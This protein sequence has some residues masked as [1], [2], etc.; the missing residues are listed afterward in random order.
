MADYPALPLLA[1]Y[2][3][4][5]LGEH[6]RRARTPLQLP[7]PF[8]LAGA[9]FAELSEAAA[10]FARAAPARWPLAL[11]LP[12]HAEL[13]RPA[14]LAGVLER[15][16][17]R[18][19]LFYESHL[20]QWTRGERTSEALAEEIIPERLQSAERIPR[21]LALLAGHE[22]QFQFSPW[23]GQRVLL[24]VF[25][26]PRGAPREGDP[27]PRACCARLELELPR[28][29]RVS[30]SLRVQPPEVHA[31]LRAGEAAAAAELREGLPRLAA[32]LSGAGLRAAALEVGHDA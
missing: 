23:P 1:L 21:Q 9:D 20:A 7:L 8:A 24:A 22:A 25:E 6:E 32:Q 31:R 26:E 16:V 13:S 30:V 3:L 17:E 14:A 2:P 12:A 19:G 28:L 18:S 11:E 10:R 29:G 15:L 5:S 27:A 4:A